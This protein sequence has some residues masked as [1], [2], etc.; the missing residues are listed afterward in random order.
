MQTKIKAKISANP[1]FIPSEVKVI[2]MAAKSLC[3]W[4]RSVSEFT[5]VWKEIDK[6]KKFVQDMDNEL[7][8]AYK[9]LHNKQLE[10]KLV[11]D[12]VNELESKYKQNKKEKDKIDEEINRT[13][14]RIE[15]AS[16]LTEGLADEQVY[17]LIFIL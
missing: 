4:V 5:D 1:N 9:I 15:N 16:Q 2:N 17:I 6:K 3:E 7:Q 13:Q 12:K 10:L 8:K 14:T 11:I